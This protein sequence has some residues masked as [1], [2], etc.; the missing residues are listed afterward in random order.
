MS[1][2]RERCEKTWNIL[3]TSQLISLEKSWIMSTVCKTYE[4]ELTEV[5]VLQ[6]SIY[7]GKACNFWIIGVFLRKISNFT[8]I[9]RFKNFELSNG[10]KIMFFFEL[11]WLF[12]GTTKVVRL[13]RGFE[14][15]GI[16]LTRVHRI[17]SE[18]VLSADFALLFDRP[19]SSKSRLQNWHVIKNCLKL[20]NNESKLWCFLVILGGIIFCQLFSWILEDSVAQH[21]VPLLHMNQYLHVQNFE[22]N[23]YA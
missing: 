21:R 7:R 2:Q 19:K 10:N 23:S 9:L 17:S 8:N 11:P 6:R 13:M 22:K 14:L 20:N 15:S 3:S 12:Q 1:I 4:F 18:R 16:E 5:E